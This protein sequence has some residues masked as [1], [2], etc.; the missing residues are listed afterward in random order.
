MAL[1]DYSSDDSE[2]ETGPPP[3]KRRR[4]QIDGAER[5]NEVEYEATS[6]QEVKVVDR[7]KAA[8]KQPARQSDLPP[9][10]EAFHDLY[11]STVRHSVVDDPS[12]HHGRKRAI[13]HIVG[14]WPSHI[15]IEWHPTAQEH[16]ALSDLLTAIQHE[17]GH[18][19]DHKLH[20]FL[21]S[22]LN[23]P[24]PLHISLSRPLALTTST[25]DSFLD[26]LTASL[27]SFSPS[28]FPSACPPAN[29]SAICSHSC[30][31]TVSPTTLAFHRS[32]DSDRTFLVLRVASNI[33]TDSP[34]DPDVTTTETD[35]VLT[36][37]AT[38]ITSTLTGTGIIG[39][40][41]H[42]CDLLR[43]CNVLASAYGHPTLYVPPSSS[44]SPCK[45]NTNNS[46]LP[47]SSSSPAAEAEAL[48]ADQAFH[49][50]IAWTFAEPPDDET[51]LRTHRLLTRPPFSDIPSWR[52]PVTAVKT[53]IGNVITHIPLASRTSSVR[54]RAR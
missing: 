8:T 40:N 47:S 10:P 41:P 43:R 25:K 35:S 20:S 18:S 23:A 21:T 48:R 14:N 36:T 1:V 50:S 29:P 16:A 2:A 26:D 30:S 52:I 7:A 19:Q 6:V 39:S 28:A 51:S 22:E 17:H 27:R 11:A 4:S 5:V 42:L 24:L 38:S 31:F 15:Y 32:P 3:A 37:A 54:R 44:A 34:H 49:I 53:K 33:T 12:L 9:L 46:A 45:I 13:P